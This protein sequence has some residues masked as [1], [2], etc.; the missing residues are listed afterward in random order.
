MIGR[1]D[2]SA[3]EFTHVT[4][5]EALDL[6]RDFPRQTFVDV[7]ARNRGSKDETAV[8]ASTLRNAGRMLGTT[9]VRRMAQ[10]LDA[11]RRASRRERRGPAAISGDRDL[12]VEREGRRADHDG[13]AR[14][15]F[16]DRD[17]G[18]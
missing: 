2:D 12:V 9:T 1:C 18:A 8:C 16:P 17:F 15:G 7:T 3:T 13:H 6:Q 11:C 5:Q 14:Q 4:Q 10:Q